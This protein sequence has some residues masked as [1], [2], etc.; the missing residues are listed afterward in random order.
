[1]HVQIDPVAHAKNGHE[2]ITF[3]NKGRRYS[4]M[5]HEKYIRDVDA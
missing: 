5:R 2:H 1:M 3:G 4:L